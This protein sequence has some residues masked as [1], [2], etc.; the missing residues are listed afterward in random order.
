MANCTIKNARDGKQLEVMVMKQSQVNDSAMEFAVNVS[1][2]GTAT[3]AGDFG[4]K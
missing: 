2:A 3:H 4:G 1:A